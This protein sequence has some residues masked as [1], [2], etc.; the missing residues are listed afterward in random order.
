[1]MK[2]SILLLF[3]FLC[4]GYVKGQDKEESLFLSDS[5]YSEGIEDKLLGLMKA[6]GGKSVSALKTAARQLIDD[7]PA[8]YHLPTQEKANELT[9]DA[10]YEQKRAAVFILG[11]LNNKGENAG[12][13]ADPIA[14]AFAISDD[15]LCVTNRHVLAELLHAKSQQAEDVS[16]RSTYYVQNVE[17]EVFLIDELLAYSSS[18]DLCI[19]KINTRGKSLS[20]LGLGEVAKVGSPVYVLAHPKQNY[21]MLTEGMVSK[22]S[23][24]ENPA[25]P[26]Q[27]QWRMSI[28]ADYAVGSSG[29]PI[30]NSKGQLAGIVS[31]TINIYGNQATQEP[32]QMVL[33]NAISVLAIKKLL[34]ERK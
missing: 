5:R 21:Y 30:L 26:N 10:I 31:S 9:A 16:D 13:F 34:K 20:F 3:L 23:K 32:F 18:N 15:G 8:T 4:F 33:K 17:G 24:L 11:R 29:G 14:T 6:D 2:K 22:N 19:F 25:N 27:V 12:A 1:M 7:Q 28:T